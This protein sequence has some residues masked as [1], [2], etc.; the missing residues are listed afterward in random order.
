MN[1]EDTNVEVEDT[2]VVLDATI[3]GYVRPPKWS[4][5]LRRWEMEVK[6]EHGE[7][8]GTEEFITPYYMETI[9]KGIGKTIK[10]HL[11]QGSGQ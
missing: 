9:D 4:W 5:S 7:H 1:K 6:W 10:V 8:K 2:T 11:D 3:V